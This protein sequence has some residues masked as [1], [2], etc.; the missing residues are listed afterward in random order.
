MTQ[1]Q[2]NQLNIE[3]TILPFY[4]KALLIRLTELTLLD[5]FKQGKIFGTVHTCIGQEFTGIAVA[6]NLLP[7][8]TLF[9][10]HRCH[11]HFLSKTNNVPGLLS[12]LMGLPSGVSGGKGGSQHLCQNGF[13]SNGIQGGIVPVAAGIAL[14]QHFSNTEN[15]SVVFIGDGTLGEGVI[16]ETLNLISKWHLPLLIVLEDNQYAQSTC[17]KQTLAGT[18]E[19]RAKAF[20]I[21]YC[22]TDTWDI[23]HLFETAK[24]AVNYVRT[25]RQPLFL[26]IHT[27]RLAA[28]SKGDDDRNID[29]INAYRMRDPLNIFEN[30]YPDLFLN[31]KVRAEKIINDALQLLEVSSKINKKL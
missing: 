21:K 25:H 22:N 17:S 2:F 24:N 14:A 23:N 28:H 1:V 6:E 8:D 9:S 30:Q 11:G 31:F 10:N 13:Y 27:Y 18:I 12:E 29:E 20:D 16:Y 7:T 26:H 19:G 5:L 15:I 4:E 3:P